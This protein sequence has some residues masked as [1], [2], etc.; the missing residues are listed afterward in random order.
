MSALTALLAASCGSN[1]FTSNVVPL[2]P[3]NFS[4]LERSPYCEASCARLQI[5]PRSHKC[6]CVTVHLP[7]CPFA[8][9]QCGS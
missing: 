1:P 6:T 2:T 4:A 5:C 8:C 3:T 9:A 7:T